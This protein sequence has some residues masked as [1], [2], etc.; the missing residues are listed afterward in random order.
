MA[1]LATLLAAVAA[2]NTLACVPATSQ[3]TSPADPAR[4]ASTQPTLESVTAAVLA[5]AA[6]RTGLEK[7]ALVVQSAEEVTWADGSLGCPAPGMNYT[8]ALVPG[9][10]ILV[11]A[12]EQV[13]DYHTTRRGDFVLCPAGQAIDPAGPVAS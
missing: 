12:G 5:D 7:T 9:Y 3:G 11:R 8:M 1:R 4:P 2:L 10:R 13:L 6:L